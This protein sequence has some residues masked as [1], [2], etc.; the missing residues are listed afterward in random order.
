MGNLTI[1]AA[2]GKNNEL[3]LNNKLIWHIPDD[4]KFFREN[5]MDKY[6]LMGKKT[7]DSLPKVLLDR[8]YLVLTHHEISASYIVKSFKTLEELFMFLNDINE[9]VMV[10]GGASIYRQ[11]LPYA[12]KMLLTEIDSQAMADTFLPNINLSEWNKELID[13]NEDENVKYKHYCYTRK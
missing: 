5:T 12:S 9:E 8:K 6:I 1:I 4:L 10:I 7:L 2:I 13:Q 3:G 11:L